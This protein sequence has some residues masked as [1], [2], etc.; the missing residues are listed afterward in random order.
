[1]LMEEA[2]ILYPS[3]EGWPCIINADLEVL[4]CFGKSDEVLSLLAHLTYINDEMD[5]I[6]GCLFA[7]WS[8]NFTNPD[9]GLQCASDAC[10]LRWA[11]EGS[12]VIL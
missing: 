9:C 8:H 3:P 1:M 11:T 5:A 7:D 4:Q 12:L 6:S 10:N 2:Q